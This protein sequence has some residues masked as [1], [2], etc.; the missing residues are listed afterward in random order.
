MPAEMGHGGVVSA[1]SRSRHQ[2]RYAQRRPWG[3]GDRDR[4]GIGS[5]DGSRG[6]GVLFIVQRAQGL[7][8]GLTQQPKGV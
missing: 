4:A 1:T 7:T 8:Q 2:Q 5:G 6:R 3:P